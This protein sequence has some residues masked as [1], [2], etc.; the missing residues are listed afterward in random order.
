VLQAG[1]AKKLEI[2]SWWT[3]GGEADGLNA[4]FGIYKKRYPGVEI[5]NATVA[6]GAGTNAKAVLQTRLAGG[7]PPDSWQ[8]HAGREALS[9]VN[10][11][12]LEPLTAFFAEQGF[13]KAMP[14]FLLD[15]LKINGEIYTVP[16]NIHRSNVMW[17]N[18]KLFQDNGLEPPKTMDDFFKAADAFKAKG[19]LPI[20]I[21]GS[22]KFEASHTFESVLL[23]TFGPDDYVKL[24]DG[25]T[26]MWDDPRAAEAIT[27]FAKV[28]SYSNTDRRRLAG[29]TPCSRCSTVRPR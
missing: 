17:Y 28:L 10:A 22:N 11:G 21:G 4:M 3:A 6:G 19:I 14:Q 12:Q 8:V 26:T 20:A 29:P 2:F 1:A 13:D 18:I 5:I 9:Y 24:W 25:T 15:Q 16:V 27:T 23:A 7:Q